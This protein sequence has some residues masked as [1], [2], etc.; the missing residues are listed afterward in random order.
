[1][2]LQR[3]L[4]LTHKLRHSLPHTHTFQM[5]RAE[6]KSARHRLVHTNEQSNQDEHKKESREE[7]K[8]P[9]T[10]TPTN[11]NIFCSYYLKMGNRGDMLN[12]KL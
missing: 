3:V 12:S 11:D 9:L 4:C 2:G 5:R 8:T 10:H 6:K 1:M 7:E